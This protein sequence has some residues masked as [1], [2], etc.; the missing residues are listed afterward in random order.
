VIENQRLDSGQT[1]SI[2]FL[3]SGAE[4]W[5]SVAKPKGWWVGF[6]KTRGDSH[7]A[8]FSGVSPIDNYG[9]S[10]AM[11]GGKP[12]K[13]WAGA[14]LRPIGRKPPCKRLRQHER[15]GSHKY[16]RQRTLKARRREC[17]TGERGI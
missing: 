6:G 9:V 1:L 11:Q 7:T 14:A 13:A 8:V 3:R 12:D 5:R 10:H 15:S 16:A 2:Q 17:V 4:Q